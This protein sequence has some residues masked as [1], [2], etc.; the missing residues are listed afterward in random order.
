MGGGITRTH[1]GFLGAWQQQ[2]LA[3]KKPQKVQEEEK[4]RIV[5]EKL[6]VV[7]NSTS[8]ASRCTE[9]LRWGLLPLGSLYFQARSGSHAT[10]WN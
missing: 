8:A 4:K 9:A 6:T 7:T 2:K 5:S 1:N 3:E 10:Q